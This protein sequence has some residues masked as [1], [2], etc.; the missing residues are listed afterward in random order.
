MSIPY[1]TIIKEKL[2]AAVMVICTLGLACTGTIVIVRGQSTYLKTTSENLSTLAELIAANSK[3]ALTFRDTKDAEEI[4][5]TL[6]N[7][8]S[9]I[10][11]SIYNRRGQVLAT[12]HRDNTSHESHQ[13]DSAQSPYISGFGDGLLTVIKVIVLDDEM[14][15]TV[16]LQ[17]DLNPMFV[18][19]KRD[20]TTV[21]VLLLF[22]SWGFML[23]IYSSVKKTIR[24]I[25]C[26][27][28][29]GHKARVSVE[30]EI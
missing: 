17:A 6:R 7:E 15:G 14:I 13:T 26:Q 2:I 18:M 19:L 30:G 12:Y 27:A 3:A 11:G 21:V 22:T 29:N 23:L 24:S 20:T 5:I 10:L 25:L 4:L 8:P 28:G 16:R 9:I 1:G